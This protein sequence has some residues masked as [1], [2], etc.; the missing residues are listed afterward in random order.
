MEGGRLDRATLT[1]ER[2]VRRVRGIEDPFA[3]RL[4]PGPADF[5][6][7]LWVRFEDEEMA[8]MWAYVLVEVMEGRVETGESALSFPSAGALVTGKWVPKELSLM[9][10]MSGQTELKVVAKADELTIEADV[11]QLEPERQATNLEAGGSSP[12]IRART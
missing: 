1:M 11:A 4:E 3:T 10:L 8:K 7:E 2:S 12:S 9:K 6:L 5:T